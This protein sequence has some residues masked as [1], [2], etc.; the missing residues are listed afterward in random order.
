MIRSVL[1]GIAITLFSLSVAVGQE[2]RDEVE[3]P[4][5]PAAATARTECTAAGHAEGLEGA[6][7]E[8]FVAAC[9]QDLSVPPAPGGEQG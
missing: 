5:D 3:A 7:L 4:Q 2:A 6:D 1:A 8:S 9:L